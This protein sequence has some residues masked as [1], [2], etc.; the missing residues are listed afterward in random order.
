MEDNHQALIELVPLNWRNILTTWRLAKNIFGKRAL[1]MSVYYTASLTPHWLWPKANRE[2]IAGV[3]GYIAMKDHIPV[4]ITGLYTFTNGPKEAWLDWYGVDEKFRG[5]GVGKAILQA[6]ID[7]ARKN[8][9][10][11]LRLWTTENRPESAIA[12]KLFQKLGFTSQKTD[13]TYSGYPVLIYSFALNGGQPS[14]YQGNVRR[15][16]A[17][18][19]YF[20]KVGPRPV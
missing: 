17:V 15:C 16:L 11:T 5:R 4:G 3:K 6:T 18:D 9:Y 1:E 10:E 7:M 13:H 8:G 12:N 20:N 2:A 14:L 19:D